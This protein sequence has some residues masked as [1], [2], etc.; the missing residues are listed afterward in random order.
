LTISAI[1]NEAGEI[2]QYV[3]LISDV[4]AHKSKS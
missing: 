2:K 1:K 3:G 4:T